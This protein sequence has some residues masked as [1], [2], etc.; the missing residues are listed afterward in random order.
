LFCSSFGSTHRRTV[1]NRLDGELQQALGDVP[2]A[3]REAL[4]SVPAFEERLMR[5]TKASGQVTNIFCFNDS[6]YIH[7]FSRLLMCTALYLN[8][9]PF[10]INL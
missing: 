7:S 8:V 6:T 3:V 4:R 5:H 10:R 1:N 2:Q 9:V